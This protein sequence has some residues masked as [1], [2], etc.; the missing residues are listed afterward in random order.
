MD[1]SETSE[2]WKIALKHRT[3][4]TALVLTRQGLPEYDRSALGYAP[5]SRLA[6]GAYVLTEDDDY[7]GIIIATGSEVEV[8]LEAKKMLNDEGIGVRVVSMPSMD[9]FDAQDEAY[10]NSVLPK[11]CRAM[12]AVEAGAS[13]PWYKYVGRNGKVIGLDSFGASAPYR[14]LYEKFGITA[15]NVAIAFKQ[16]I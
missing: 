5:A 10:R 12:V 8:A 1:A 13:L 2:A 11:I 3:G 16:M 7:K 4:P 6:K 15:E 9:I 14:T